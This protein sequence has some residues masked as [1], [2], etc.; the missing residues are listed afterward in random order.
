MRKTNQEQFRVEKLIKREGNKLYVKWKD[1]NS[2]FNSWTDKLDIILT[3]E[4][5]PKLKSLRAIVKVELDLS[6]YATK[7]DLQ[8]LI[9]LERLKA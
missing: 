5:F 3:S 2:Y 1:Y 6:N 8:V 4:Y 7:A 9:L